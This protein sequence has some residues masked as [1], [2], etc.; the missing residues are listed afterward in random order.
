MAKSNNKTEYIPVAF[1]SENS[2]APKGKNGKRKDKSANIYYTMLMSNAWRNLTGNQK[3]LY[4][5]CKLQQFGESL[6]MQ[7]HATAQEKENDEKPNLSDRFTMNKSKWCELYRLYIPQNAKRF[8]KD[9]QALIDNGFV[10][11]LQSGFTDRSKNIYKFSSK[12]K[13]FGW[14]TDKK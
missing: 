8:Y 10:E 3:E 2:V 5:F 6:S 14:V 12:W 4:L 1:E 11:K 13:E 7:E 9:M